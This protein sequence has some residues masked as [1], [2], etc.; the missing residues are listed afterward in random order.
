MNRNRT[1]GK[2]SSLAGQVLKN[3]QASVIQKTLA[4]SALSQ[5]NSK[6]QTSSKMETVASNVLHSHKYSATT[7]SLAGSILSQSDKKR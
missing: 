6:N 2:V 7:Q 1:G 4:G 5:A 3:P